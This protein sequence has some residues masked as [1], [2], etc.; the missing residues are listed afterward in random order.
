MEVLKHIGIF[1]I[2]YVCLC[3]AADPK[4]NEYFDCVKLPP[5]ARLILFLPTSLLGVRDF[6]V[7]I[8]PMQA[9]N[10]L[11]WLCYAAVKLILRDQTNILPCLI[12]TVSIAGPLTG[13]VWH[14]LHKKTDLRRRPYWHER[15]GER[16]RK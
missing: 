12:I 14:V 13:I 10:L 5:V 7:V 8:I 3:V 11:A 15:K 9:A 2:L 16:K 4:P 6:R 1:L